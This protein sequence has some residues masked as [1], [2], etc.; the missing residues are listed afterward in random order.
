MAQIV[1]DTRRLLDAAALLLEDFKRRRAETER[2]LDR[3]EFG[4]RRNLQYYEARLSRFAEPRRPI[5]V[6][7]A[8]QVAA[9]RIA[10]DTDNETYGAVTQAAEEIARLSPTPF[11]V[12]YLAKELVR[13]RVRPEM[14][15]AVMSARAAIKGLVKRNILKPVDRGLFVHARRGPLWS[16]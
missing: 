9:T 5:L 10:S 8:A 3:Q 14:H 16:D 4:L 2:D 13:R 7:P 15:S 11:N 12:A 6:T 1:E